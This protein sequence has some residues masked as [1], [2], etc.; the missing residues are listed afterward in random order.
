M[1]ADV[2]GK[3]VLMTRYFR[4]LEPPAESSLLRVESLTHGVPTSRSD[5]MQVQLPTDQIRTCL[6]REESQGMTHNDH[7][8]LLIPLRFPLLRD[9][10]SQKL[11]H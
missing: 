6:Q 10:L 1:V 7:L 3:S 4:A 2:T 9:K 8:L 11:A 5:Q